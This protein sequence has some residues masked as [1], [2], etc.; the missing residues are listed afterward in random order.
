MENLDLIKNFFSNNIA[1]IQFIYGTTFLLITTM[2]LVIDKKESDFAISKIFYL[3]VLYTLPHALSDY[4]SVWSIIKGYDGILLNIKKIITYTSYIFLFEFG[5]RLFIIIDPKRW[6]KSHYL[7]PIIFAA[8]ITSALLTGDFFK[9]IDAFIGYFLR[10]PAGIMIGLGLRQYYKENEKKLSGL[11]LYKYFFT[12]GIALILW[13]FFCG[14][15]RDKGTV[16]PANLLYIDS[17]FNYT[18]I[19]V[20]LFRTICGIIILW[21]MHGILSIFNWETRFRIKQAYITEKNTNENLDNILSN[22][23]DIMIVINKN[24]EI[25]FLNPAASLL[26]G[27]ESGELI[28]EKIDL[29]LVDN[30][31]FNKSMESLVKNNKNVMRSEEKL[32]TK[33][34]EEI[35][36]L[37]S[38][39]TFYNKNSDSPDIIAIGKDITERKRLEINLNMAYEQKTDEL[40]KRSEELES[41]CKVLELE[42]SDHQKTAER[43]YETQYFLK[44]IMN[45][46]TDSI[47]VINN[48]NTIRMANTAAQLQYGIDNKTTNLLCYEKLKSNN[49]FCKNDMKK[50]PLKIVEETHSPITIEHRFYNDDSKQEEYSEIVASPFFNNDNSFAGIIEVIRNITKRKE[51]EKEIITISE[52]ER[53]RIGQDIHDDIAQ[54]LAAIDILAKILHSHIAENEADYKD[55]LSDIIQIISGTLNNSRL[56]ARGLSPISIENE[57]IRDIIEDFSSETRSLFQIECTYTIEGNISQVDRFTLIQIYYIIKESLSNI[58]KHSNCNSIHISLFQENERVTL[59]IIDDGVGFEANISTKGLGLKIMRYRSEVING[60][61]LIRSTKNQGTTISLTFENYN[62][63]AGIT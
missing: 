41:T 31:F 38:Y 54:N 16:F 23:A 39:S 46:I 11:R 51:L 47:L 43:Y 40:I 26:L 8:I 36:L 34:N 3:F 42:K 22:I 24:S 62:E 50:C 10:F 52:K 58:V 30:K 56:L 27:Y 48:D 19:P 33:N 15:I 61:M 17:F 6:K 35:P 44:T 18:Y 37:I 59:E 60:M 9:N 1:F 49:T 4:I 2:I 32:T 57:N 14:I 7:Y 29:I 20:Y 53:Q 28:G 5:R 21:S 13:A 12:C 25:L 63:F 45:S 55:K